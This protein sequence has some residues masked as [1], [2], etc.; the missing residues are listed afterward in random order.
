MF[1]ALTSSIP[2]K[3]GLLLGLLVLL[4][5]ALIGFALWRMDYV[6]ATYTKVVR[7]DAQAALEV[8]QAHRSLQ[9]YGRQIAR[10]GYADT[11]E[12]RA[13][14]AQRRQILADD[15]LARMRRASELANGRGDLVADLNRR[16]ETLRGHV[17]GIARMNEAGDLAGART[18]ITRDFDPGFDRL[19]DDLDA[20][21]RDSVGRLDAAAKY[22]DGVVEL[23]IWLTLA[24][25]AFGLLLTVAQGWLI[26]VRGI[27]RPLRALADGVDEIAAGKYA[28]A[29]V[30]VDRQD[31]IGRLA[32]AVDQLRVKAGEAA[33][34]Q[35]DASRQ[36]A[37]REKRRKA[38]DGFAA[39][40]SASIQGV[41]AQ[42]ADSA[43][44]MR[45]VSGRVTADAE[46]TSVKA[47]SVDD[48]ARSTAR[49]LAS[50]SAAAEEMQA[51]I[52]EIAR[53]MERA[54]ADTE[55]TAR[56]AEAAETSMAELTAAASEIGKVVELIGEIAAQTNLLALN[57]TIEAARAGE[58]GKGFAVVASE[59][60]N[61]ATQTARATTDITGRID[62]IRD[63]VQG[64]VARIHAIAERIRGLNETAA[65]VSGAVTE[66]G[67]ATQEVV[68]AVAAAS[69]RM[70][71]V[72][73]ASGEMTRVARETTGAAG[74]VS[75][76]CDTML[77]QAGA[78][79]GEIDGFLE[80]LSTAS[81]RREFERV[82]CSLGARAALPAGAIAL[83]ATDISRGGA[84][85]DRRLDLKLG[86]TFELTL[87]GALRAV[88]VRVARLAAD[89][90]GVTFAQDAATS[91]ALAPVF[92][93]LHAPEATARRAA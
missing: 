68:R 59:V 84:K 71:G 48:D 17:V 36:A 57:A 41:L 67:A 25:G 33:N 2:R 10:Y 66:Q 56:E 64:A 21:T 81:E 92:E 6:N 78:L 61:L 79:R 18:A 38:V 69:Q 44:A 63:S 75:G 13:S 16:F 45:D 54:A 30:G 80:A 62:A 42:V 43:G 19:R 8:A 31:E 89:A 34:L 73:A 26:G 9:G 5:V 82:V 65:G 85:L 7:G 53:Q 40:F 88:T 72:S 32:R 70:E 23:T 3:I 76:A 11:P 87:D 83:R 15:Y 35:A 86:A 90:T 28:T 58:A 93:A 74:Q 24:I 39:D 12:T 46:S 14:I 51:S 27:S 1:A 37:L 29:A 77:A 55:R 60:K 4:D 47:A 50:V 22:A 49:D 52:A 91:A 20:F